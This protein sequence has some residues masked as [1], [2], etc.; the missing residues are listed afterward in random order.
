MVG[1]ISRSIL[2]ATG[3]SA[4][5][6]TALLFFHLV[7]AEQAPM[8]VEALVNQTAILRKPIQTIQTIQT[9][10][11]VVPRMEMS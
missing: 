1:T 3:D 2:M 4:K 11:Q 6:A 7:V 10:Y 5:M 8:Q 9:R